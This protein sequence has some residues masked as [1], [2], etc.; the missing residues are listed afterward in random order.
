MI[1]T[2]CGIPCV[3]EITSVHGRYIPAKIY[4][5]PDDCYEAQY[6]EVEWTVFDRKGYP[7]PWLEKKLTVEEAARIEADL[8]A[9]MS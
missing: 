2:I 5:D 7:A 4:A 1:T 8:I 3:A 9:E 6:P